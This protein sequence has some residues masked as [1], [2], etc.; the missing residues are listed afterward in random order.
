SC[1]VLVLRGRNS[2]FLSEQTAERML[3]C[4]PQT[5]LVEFDNTGH[6]PTLRNDEQV[7]VIED[8]LAEN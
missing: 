7:K 5:D 3:A 4:G 8:W 6:T 1:P 2:T